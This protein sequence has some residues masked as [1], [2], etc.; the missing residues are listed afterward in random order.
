MTIDISCPLKIRWPILVGFLLVSFTVVAIVAWTIDLG[1]LSAGPNDPAAKAYEAG[2]WSTAARLAN[3]RLRQEKNDIDALR[4]LARAT[5]RQGKDELATALYENR[6]KIDGMEAEDHFLL[7]QMIAR[8]GNAELAI[9]VWEKAL[10]TDPEHAEMLES[11]ACLSAQKL[12]FEEAVASASKL[13]LRPG[14]EATGHLLA[15][16]FRTSM[17]DPRG[18]VDA[19]RKAFEIDPNVKTTFLPPERISKLYARNLLRIGNAEEAAA[20]LNQAMS[21]AAGDPETDWLLSRAELQLGQGRPA[22]DLQK[23]GLAY[24]ES[25][26][27]ELEPA[28]FA[29]ESQCTKCHEDIAA[30]YAKTRHASSF[31]S[32]ASLLHLP[33]PEKPLTDPD[34]PSV[35]HA[36]ERKGDQIE[37]VT[38]RDDKELL[39]VLV[40]YAFGTP[41]RYV[42][43]VGQDGEG[44]FRAARFSHYSGKDGSGWD[45]T[46]GDSGSDDK[47]ASVLGQAVHT[48][49]G[50]VRCLACHVTSPRDFRK[51]AAEKSAAFAD[52]GLGCESCHGPGSNHLKAVKAER[53]DYAIR[54]LIGV[55]GH[56]MNKVCV[57]CHTVGDPAEIRATPDDPKWVRSAGVT[58]TMSRCF[59]ESQGKLS[60][61]TCHDPHATQKSSA[62]AYESKCISC[63]SRPNAEKASADRLTTQVACKTGA[64]KDCIACHMPKIEVPVLHDSLTDHF[65]RV[66]K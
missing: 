56:G 28:P 18:S 66:R 62:N 31:R 2:D 35:E 39:R 33:M 38:R 37:I 58:F 7:G 53:P 11:F 13:A 60:C 65:I 34:D 9:G 6:V 21:S 1:S 27:L 55:D 61:T 59:T 51:G 26:P 47:S 42:T 50:V 20:V 40:E 63:H 48:R 3:E 52:K 41:D 17:D 10:A 57:D 46:S 8:Q 44:Q 4:L 15:G 32:G 16:I 30:S 54:S 43:M 36:Y 23:K 49:D 5:A 45:R 64:T 12:H 19:F 25:N 24:R 14:R 22:S 29:G